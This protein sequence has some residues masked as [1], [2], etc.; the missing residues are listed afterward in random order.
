[1]FT[2][3]ISKKA[4]AIYKEICTVNSTKVQKANYFAHACKVA[5]KYVNAIKKGIVKF[6]KIKD[7]N[8]MEMEL[9]ERKVISLED[10]GY[11]PTTDRKTKESQL[12][13]IDLEKVFVGKERPFISFNHWQMAW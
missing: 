9:T 3:Q 13:F 5:Y 8:T 4:W 11:C 7:F 12:T 1:M 2:S 6:F 10:F